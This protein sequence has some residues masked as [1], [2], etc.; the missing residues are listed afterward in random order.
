VEED[1]L[2]G[3]FVGNVQPAPEN[4]KVA[5]GEG[6]SGEKGRTASSSG[7]Q[8]LHQDPT[9]RTFHYCLGEDAGPTTPQPL[10]S[11]FEGKKFFLSFKDDLEG[12]ERTM[13]MLM[14]IGGIVVDE[15]FDFIIASPLHDDNSILAHPHY[16]EFWLVRRE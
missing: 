12:H 6:S 15:N 8:L 16:T 11:I 9:M 13:D 10:H 5:P 1:S 14:T 7:D 2:V 3:Y 4:E